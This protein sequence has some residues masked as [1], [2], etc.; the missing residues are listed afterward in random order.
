MVWDTWLDKA[1][2]DP[3]AANIVNT[4]ETHP[5]EELYDTVSDP[6]ELNNIAEKPEARAVLL[7][8]RKQLRTWLSADDDGSSLKLYDLQTDI[9]EKTNLAGEYTEITERLSKNVLGW[10][11]S[12]ESPL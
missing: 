11:K 5:R 12:L 6:Y 1:K 9:G 8:M 7:R 3:V 10:R 2:T 4:N